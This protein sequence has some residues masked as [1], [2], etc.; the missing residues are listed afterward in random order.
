M[1][2]L[3][4]AISFSNY[5][6]HDLISNSFL[7]SL[8]KCRRV[9]YWYCCLKQFMVHYSF[10]CHASCLQLQHKQLICLFSIQIHNASLVSMLSWYS[11]LRVFTFFTFQLTCLM[12]KEIMS[13]LTQCICIT[14]SVQCFVFETTTIELYIYTSVT[15]WT[16]QVAVQLN[17]QIVQLVLGMSGVRVLV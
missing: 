1:T 12:C 8:V 17:W 11:I 13:L 9:L 2:M 5:F 10:L 16:R 15:D 7:M 4:N 14:A 6:K 3:P